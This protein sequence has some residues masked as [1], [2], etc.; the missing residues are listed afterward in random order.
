M[1]KKKRIRFFAL[2]LTLCMCV[3]MMPA[4]AAAADD[5]FVVSV[6]DTTAEGQENDDDYT[7]EYHITENDAVVSVSGSTENSRIIVEAS[8][9]TITLDDVSMVLNDCN[10]SPIEITKGKS[11][12]LIL[13]GENRLTASFRDGTLCRVERMAGLPLRGS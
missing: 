7:T 10:G 1:K 8:N 11:A 5:P 12:T 3:G 2:L 13:K 4:S 9:V 6:G